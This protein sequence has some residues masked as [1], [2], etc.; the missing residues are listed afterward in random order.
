MKKHLYNIKANL[1]IAFLFL[2]FACCS[3]SQEHIKVYQ[4][5]DGEE[6]SSM[7]EVTVEG[8]KI[9]V[10]PVKVGA[11]EQGR[12]W[13]AMDDPVSSAEYYD[14]AAF[15]Y[16]DMNKPVLVEVKVPKEIIS[17]KILPSS[18]GIASLIDGNTLSFRIEKPEKLTIKINGEKIKSLH[19]FAN[20]F[21]ENIPDKN[22]P[23]VIYFGPG[24]HEITH[25]EIGDN[26]TLYIAGGAVLKAMIGADEKA[27]N[28]NPNGLKYYSPTIV[29][30]GKNIKVKGRGIIDA[31]NTPTHSRNMLVVE[32]EDI[33][34]EGIILKDPSVWTVPVR[35]SKNVLIENIKIIG[36]R[37][38]SDGI[39]ICGSFDVEVNN[40]FIRTL[41]DL[42][43]I[44]T[45]KGSG[46]AGR[47]LVHRCVLWNELAH[48]LSIGAELTKDV[49]DVVFRDCDIIR[50]TGREWS[51]RVFQSDK[52]LIS[53]IRFENIRIEESTKLISLWIGKNRW[54]ND[55]EGGNIRNI[56]FKDIRAKG[57]PLTVEFTGYD[58]DHKIDSVYFENVT[59]NGEKLDM[60]GIK[61]NEFVGDIF[62]KE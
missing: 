1:L 14:E 48:A 37:A 56:T 53:N 25:L 27:I 59:I 54:T 38:N 42:V 43:V 51:L 49:S 4:A 29:L 7:Y 31:T 44:K 55:D 20:P 5:P 61:K 18:A 17:A 32:G 15:S 41:D 21:E 22:D 13:K 16:F 52:A 58:N 8:S 26:K 3:N 57:E 23:D 40:C 30:K 9:P 28:T 36:Y 33:G 11:E 10:Y 6:L 39:D 62:F 34:V 50:D 60:S 24:V 35:H 2:F 45:L 12:R 19:I 47:I 46:E